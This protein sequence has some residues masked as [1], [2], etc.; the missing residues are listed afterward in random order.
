[1]YSKTIRT[2]GNGDLCGKTKSFYWG[3]IMAV[4]KFSWLLLLFCAA[5]CYPAHTQ[6][7]QEIQQLRFVQDD[8]QDKMVSKVYVLKYVQSNDIIPFLLGIVKRYN[9]NSTVGSIVFG[10]NNQQILTVTCPVKMMPYV[11]DFIAKADRDVQVKGKVPGEIIRGTGITRA[12]YQPKYRSG[13]DLVNIIVNAI[14]GEGPYGSVYGYDQNSNQI[15]WKDNASN[16]SYVF[17]FLEWLDRPAPQ[18]SFHFNVYEVRQ[19][20]MRD[21]GLDYLAWKNGPGMNIFQTSFQAMDLSSSGSAALQSFSGPMGG[22]LFAPQFD[23]SFLRLL[24]QNGKADI[25]NTAS[26]T[27]ANSDSRNYSLMFS[28]QLQN[29]YKA[30]NDKTTVGTITSLPEGSYQIYLKITSPMVNL[31]GGEPMSGYPEREAF[32]IK[33]YTPGDYT[34]RWGSVVFG[35]SIQTANVVERNNFGHELIETGVINGNS[36]ICLDQ[37]IILARWEKEQDVEQVIGIPWLSDIPVL[38]YL[39]STTTTSRE[40]IHVY[41]TVKAEMLNT[42]LPSGVHPGMVKQIK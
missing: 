23:A 20:T 37:E 31:P 7:K 4:S 9:M 26:I 15:Y 14:V 21:I 29:I 24:Q 28:P 3:G 42:T 8:A 6:E 5:V 33:N 38:K 41:M 35:Y 25:R 19:S 13:Q 11:D 27:V 1:M 39:F 32:S 34:N 12:V 2:A 17:Q 40:K 22:F 10:N 30:D 16:S 36:A 18:I